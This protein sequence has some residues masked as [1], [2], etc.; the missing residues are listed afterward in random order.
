MYMIDPHNEA[1]NGRLEDKS[2]TEGGGMSRLVTFHV[3]LKKSFKRLSSA[4]EM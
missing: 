3:V 2:Q 1:T 4:H